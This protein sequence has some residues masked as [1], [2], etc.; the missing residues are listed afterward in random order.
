MKKERI[1]SAVWL[2]AAFAAWT[3]A[4]C[5]VDLQPMGPRETEVG[6]ASLNRLVHT[7]T[8]VNMGLYVLTDWLSLIPLLCVSGFGLLGLTQWIRRKEIRKVDADLLLLGGF[9]VAVMA[10]YA[11][12]ETVVVNYRPVL[13]DGVL[14]ASYP[15]STTVLVMCVMGTA[16]IQMHRRIQN[17]AVRYG[18]AFAVTAFSYVMVIGRLL[19]G[20][21]WL[22]DIIGG[23]LLSAGLVRLYGFFCIKLRQG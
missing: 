23:V 8:G 4:V 19:S 3:A 1:G 10:V 9:Y 7:L 2:L 18:A 14:E 15:S 16:K 17:R 21:H 22:T 13:I 12:F 11:L 6:F 20:V 5:V